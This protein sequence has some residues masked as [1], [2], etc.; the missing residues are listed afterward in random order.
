MPSNLAI[1]IILNSVQALLNVD[2]LMVNVMQGQ[3]N[4]ILI[5]MIAI[6]QH[7][8]YFIQYQTCIIVTVQYHDN[9]VTLFLTH[10][11]AGS[12]IIF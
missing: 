2:P 1:N 9:G 11:D 5:I 6:D 8:N 3:R 10:I 12:C 7:L 4:I